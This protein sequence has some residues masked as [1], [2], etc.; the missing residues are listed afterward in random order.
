MPHIFPFAIPPQIPA[1]PPHTSQFDNLCF[2]DCDDALRKTAEQHSQTLCFWFILGNMTLEKKN[3]QLRI[4]RKTF[5]PS[6]KIFG[7][8]RLNKIYIPQRTA[9]FTERIAGVFRWRR[10]RVARRIGWTLSRWNNRLRYPH[11]VANTV[12][13][14]SWQHCLDQC[15]PPTLTSNVTHV[16]CPLLLRSVYSGLQLN[17]PLCRLEEEQSSPMGAVWVFVRRFFLCLCIISINVTLH[18]N[19][20]S[21]DYFRVGMK[22]VSGNV[23]AADRP[24]LFNV[25][26]RTERKKIKLKEFS[27]MWGIVSSPTQNK[28]SP[29]WM[30]RK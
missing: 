18:Y 5:N 17:L 12:E 14:H 8:F 26:Y 25:C 30:Q 7:I 3:C 1:P 28:V 15:F 16:S 22:S 11:W 4:L 27:G 19:R 10:D 29:V 9:A 24:E 20:G 2:R 21:D 6:S 23:S 13:K